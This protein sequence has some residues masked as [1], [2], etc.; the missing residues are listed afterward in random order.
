MHDELVEAIARHILLAH[1][2][3]MNVPGTDNETQVEHEWFDWRPEA[4]AALAAHTEWLKANGF[5]VVPVGVMSE[6]RE[7]LE[8]A[9]QVPIA[10]PNIREA[11]SKIGDWH[12]YGNLMAT[13]SVLWREK[14]GDLQGGEF[15]NGPCRVTVERTLAMLTVAQEP[16]K[17]MG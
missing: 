3:D 5:A 15:V 13:A 10:D 2:E 4:H 17:G 7:V 11:V 16:A 12:G 14:L 8:L 9:A 1:C 6:V